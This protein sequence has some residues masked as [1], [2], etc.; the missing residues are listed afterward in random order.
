MSR[1]KL[2]I[3]RMSK[4][5]LFRTSF[6]IDSFNRFSLWPAFVL[7]IVNSYKGSLFGRLRSA[8]SGNNCLKSD[9]KAREDECYDSDR[10]GGTRVLVPKLGGYSHQKQFEDYDESTPRV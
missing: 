7:T 8:S 1:W 2:V 5:K 4:K 3:Q 10:I 6:D 9:A